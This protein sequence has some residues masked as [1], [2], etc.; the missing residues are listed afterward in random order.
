MTFPHC[1]NPECPN[2]DN[3][4]DENWFARHGSHHTKAFG[5][6]RRYRCKS[7]R[8]TFS[9]QTFSIDYYAKKVIDY[10]FLLQ[11]VVT[12]SGLNDIS[13]VMEVSTETVENRCERLARSCL[14]IHSDL[15]QELTLIEDL[16][17][18]GFESFSHSQHFPNNINIFVGAKSEFIYAQSFA[19]L[20]RKGRMTPQQ[21][22]KRRELE[23]IAKADPKAIEK[24]FRGLV[25]DL[26]QFLKE[27]DVTRKVITTDE[28]KAYPRAFAK[29]KEFAQYFIQKT[30]SS[31]KART[32][33]NPLFPVNYIDRQIRKD[34]SDHVRE[35]V[36]F[37]KCPSAMMIRL[38]IY[39]Y[40]HNCLIARRVCEERAGNPETHA[41]RAGITRKQCER[42]GGEALAEE[43]LPAQGQTG[44]GRREDLAV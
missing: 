43:A 23:A 22:K 8:K 24:S 34:V 19:N 31:R 20:R 41:E 17:A 11:Q 10:Q 12:A 16:A 18:D 38:A 40:H 28:H 44:R 7:C 1:P 27:K 9:A 35:T 14:A 29:V 15:L 36:Q 30:V 5:T 13:R 39:R 26:I 21:K 32:I 2:F 33:G 25:E 4:K 3:P 37:A 6:V 42:G